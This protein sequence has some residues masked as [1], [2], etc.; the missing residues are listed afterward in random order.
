MGALGRFLL[1]LIVRA[2]D[3]QQMHC[4]LAASFGP[5]PRW[6]GSSCRKGAFLV[7]W[8]LHTPLELYRLDL[9]VIYMLHWN[10]WIGPLD[11]VGA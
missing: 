1:V 9:V 2:W 7:D 11:P 3:D 6:N 4:D 10:H 5:D 8:A